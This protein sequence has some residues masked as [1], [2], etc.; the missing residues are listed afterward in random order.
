MD[1]TSRSSGTAARCPRRLIQAGSSTVRQSRRHIHGPATLDLPGTVYDLCLDVAC[2]VLDRER[3]GVTVGITPG[4]Y[5]DFQH[6]DA[7]SFQTTGRIIG[8]FRI[9]SRWQIVGGVA[10]VRQLRSHWLP[11]G[12]MVWTPT[13]DW[14]LDLAVPRPRLARRMLQTEAV[15]L[16]GYVAGQFGGGSWAVDDGTG[17]NVLLGYNDLRLLAGLNLWR[18]SGRELMA[19]LGYV[20]SRELA[21]SEIS[22]FT[23]SD[24]WVAQLAWVF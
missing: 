23:P 5:G 15:D 19:E 16:W 2:R 3:G 17:R 24:A 14:Q 11:I 20:F 12:G 18:A 7:Q 4:F 1:S 13:D 10:V 6:V 22:V 21:V 8:D 9:N